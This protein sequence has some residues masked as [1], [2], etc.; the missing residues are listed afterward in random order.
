MRHFQ[1]SNRENYCEKRAGRGLRRERV[2][3]FPSLRASFFRL[4]YFRDIPSFG[5]MAPVF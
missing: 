4:A 2:G 5:K 3:A 1:D